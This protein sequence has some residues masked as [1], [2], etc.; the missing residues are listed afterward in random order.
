MVT[1]LAGGASR[2][3][4]SSGYLPAGGGHGRRAPRGRG[5]MKWPHLA[6]RLAPGAGEKPVERSSLHTSSTLVCSASDMA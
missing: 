2:A 5:R 6:G 3:K 4:Y 1:K